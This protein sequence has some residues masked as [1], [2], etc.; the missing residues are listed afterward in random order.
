MIACR[1][2]VDIDREL[3]GKAGYSRPF[4]IGTLDHKNGIVISID[5]FGVSDTL[6]TRQAPVRNGNAVRGYH[7]G[8][9]VQ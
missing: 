4:D 7:F 5:A 8:I 9:L 3:I 2:M 1:V 6:G